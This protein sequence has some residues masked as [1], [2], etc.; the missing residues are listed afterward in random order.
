M[1]IHAEAT[2][3]LVGPHAGG[4]REEEITNIAIRAINWPQAVGGWAPL[5]H[6]SK[7]PPQRFELTGGGPHIV[8]RSVQS[9]DQ[10]WKHVNQVRPRD[11]SRFFFSQFI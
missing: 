5:V 7:L 8:S 9:D 10:T 6:P 3:R 1:T 2:K 4:R 11:S